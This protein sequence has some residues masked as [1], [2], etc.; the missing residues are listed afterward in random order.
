MPQRPLRLGFI[1]G[2]TNSAIGRA[3]FNA[4]AL[5]GLYRLEAGCFSR[6]ADINAASAAAYGVPAEHTYADWRQM[7]AAERGRLDAVAILTPTSD[8]VAPAVALLDAGYPVICEK[9][10]AASADDA[11]AI[12]DA[13]HRHGGF[14]AVTFNYTGYPALREMRA[15]L[16]GGRLGQLLHFEADMPQE[17]FIRRQAD[18]SPIRPQDWRLRD[19]TIPTVYLDLGVHLHQIVHYLC[20]LRPGAVSAFHGSFGN[21]PQVVDFV[22]ASACYENGVHGKFHFGKSMLGHRNGLA[23]RLYGSDA[24][25]EWVQSRPEEIRIAH[26]DGRIELLDRGAATEV[27]GQ[28]RYTR[29]KAG[30]P[31]GY[32]EAF[33]NLYVDIHAALCAHRAGTPA[34]NDEVFGTDLAV[35]GLDFLQAM[36]D[37]A[38][39]RQWVSLGG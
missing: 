16:A 26:Y 29:F 3:H 2:G 4:T 15:L 34:P 21:F 39:S 30:H 11:R 10:L 18:G 13:E 17:G 14:L 32:V 1:G 36:A 6:H 33:A 38:N 37:S 20:G 8:H 23:L 27:A 5:D 19:G 24:S 28:A 12:R 9:A 31:A 35:A 25:A 7:L 22:S